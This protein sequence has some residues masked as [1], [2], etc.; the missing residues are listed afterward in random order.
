[1]PAR[2]DVF[3]VSAGPWGGTDAVRCIEA[4]SVMDYVQYFSRNGKFDPACSAG[5]KKDL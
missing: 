4:A 1:M 3:V 2:S 5:G